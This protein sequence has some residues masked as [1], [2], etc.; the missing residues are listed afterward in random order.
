MACSV[1]KSSEFAGLNP[2]RRILC[3]HCEKLLS[4]MSEKLV[5]TKI[6]ADDTI[7]EV[8]EK[9]LPQEDIK[10]LLIDNFNARFLSR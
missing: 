8:E 1:E 7:I 4:P 5:A 6:I 2:P 3:S 10:G 9:L